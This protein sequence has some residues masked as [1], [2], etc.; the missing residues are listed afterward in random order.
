MQSICTVNINFTYS[1]KYNIFKHMPINKNALLRYKTLDRCFRNSG[2]TYFIENL[3]SE[4][5]EALIQDDINSKGVQ[6]RQLRSDI[7]FMRSEAGFGAPIE[8]KIFQGRKEIYFYSDTTFSI[9]NS[10]NTETE[11]Q[12]LKN[13]FALFDWFEDSPGFEWMKETKIF[14]QSELSTNTNKKVVAFDNN[15]DYKG[16][17][18]FTVLFNG[19]IQKKVLSITYLTFNQEKF[20]VIFHPYYL[21][22][23]NSRW[24]VFG[25]NEENNRPTTNFALDRIEEIIETNI[26]YINS[27]T[28]WI[29][30]FSDMIGVSRES[31][32]IEKVELLFS[33][34]RGKYVETKPLHET[35]RSKWSE[36]GLYV[37]I[38]VIKN[39]ELV[40]TI[41]SFG[42]DVKVL[43]PKYLVEEITLEISKMSS[44]Y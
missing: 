26:T 42:S 14:L 3:L 43:S 20:N 5:N 6:I 31:E 8:S 35:Q 1:T 34:S 36:D 25:L 2:R 30:F 11:A 21:K 10:K 16:S 19:I 24:F 33:S 27:E 32:T 12:M 13:S 38:D 4:V 41:L 17:N 15:I 7:R 39:R 40:Q 9:H 28:N 23:Y 29:E 37:K 44:L 22:Q 18:W